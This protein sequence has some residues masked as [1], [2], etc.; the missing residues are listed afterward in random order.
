[1]KHHRG[2]SLP[3][4]SGDVDEVFTAPQVDLSL[5][6]DN[7][8]PEIFRSVPADILF[9]VEEEL[10]AMLRHEKGQKTEGLI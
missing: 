3:H 10:K 2:L 1:M 4:S 7:K 6:G 5:D 8:Q 9:G